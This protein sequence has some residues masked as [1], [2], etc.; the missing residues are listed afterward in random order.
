MMQC[1]A[2]EEPDTGTMVPLYHHHRLLGFVNMMDEP[3]LH[4][5]TQPIT[6]DVLETKFRLYDRNSIREPYDLAAGVHLPYNLPELSYSPLKNKYDKIYIV[7]HDFQ[8]MC[9][10]KYEDFA[11]QLL[12]YKSDERPAVILGD[13]RKGAMKEQKSEAQLPELHWAYGQAVANTIVVGRE[14][15]LL[16]YILTNTSVISRSNLHYIGVGLGAQVMHFA[17][18]WYKYLEDVVRQDSGEPRGIW[19][20]GR[21]TG[22]DPSARDFQGYGTVDKLP[23]LNEQD[24]DFVDIIHTSAVKNGGDD[25]DIKNGRYGMSV[26]AGHADFYPNGGQEQPFCKD[27]PRC[28]HQMAQ[29][30][31]AASL[32]NDSYVKERL[33]SFSFKSGGSWYPKGKLSFLQRFLKPK[34]YSPCSQRYMGIEATS[35][36]CIQNEDTRRAYYSDFALDPEGTVATVETIDLQELQLVD[37]LPSTILSKEGYD[38]SKFPLVVPKKT[39]DA[40]PLGDSRLRSVPGATY[41]RRSCSLWS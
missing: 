15:A 26:L 9:D 23:Y 28:S 36:I 10:Y 7:V 35:F 30:Y 34:V 1:Y 11:Y 19:R 24:A 37:K 3:H 27:I 21:I 29:K 4:L 31:F 2:S 12:S 16:S 33:S 6:P 39:V 17:G 18:Q 32:T 40:P 22:L 13:W 25:E 38:F 14:V 41:R 20:V 5:K 8:E